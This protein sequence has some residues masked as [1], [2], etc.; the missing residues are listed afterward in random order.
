MKGQ[1]LIHS[2]EQFG[3]EINPARKYAQG[4][5]KVGNVIAS[6]SFFAARQS[7]HRIGDCFTRLKSAG[8]S[9]TGHICTQQSSDFEKTIKYGPGF[10]EAASLSLPIAF[11]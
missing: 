7:S 10:Y 5:R 11:F 9:M 1:K 6:R 8:F 3:F 2:I 4:F